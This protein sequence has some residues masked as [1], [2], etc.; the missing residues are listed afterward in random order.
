MPKILSFSDPVLTGRAKLIA[1]TSL[2]LMLAAGRWCYGQWLIGGDLEGI[3]V[4]AALIFSGV[5][6]GLLA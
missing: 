2:G 5:M 1:V 3:T 6:T 4:V